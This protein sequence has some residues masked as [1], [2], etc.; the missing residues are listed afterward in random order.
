M[1]GLCFSNKP[2]QIIKQLWLKNIRAADVLRQHDNVNSEHLEP[3][4][5]GLPHVVDLS[6]ARRR[7][8]AQRRQAL[9]RPVESDEI[10]AL[11]LQNMAAHNAET[12]AAENDEATAVRRHNDAL[13]V[14][15]T[16][17]AENDEARAVR[18]QNMAA[19]NA[20]TRAA[21]NDEARAVRLQN[22]AANNAATRAAENDEARA[23]RLQNMAANNAATR[24]AENDEAAAVRRRNVA[25]RVAARRADNLPFHNFARRDIMPE[26]N[27]IGSMT[28]VCE[29]CHALK[30]E[31]ENSF[32]C[33]HG[34]KVSLPN[35]EPY[36][37]ELSD[38]MLEDT[39]QG[40]N[41]RA[42]I[43][44]F[45]SAF[46]F[47]SFGANIAPPPGRGP[48]CFRL[49]GQVV[50]RSGTLH[51]EHGFPPSYSQLY[52][53]DGQ[54]ALDERMN[55]NENRNCHPD[56]MRTIQ[57]VMHRDNPYALAFKHMSEVEQ[58]EHLIA[59]AENRLP[60]EV[61]MYMKVAG[62][63]RRYNLPHHDEVAAV[64]VGE[65]GAPPTSRGHYGLSAK[66]LFGN[67]FND[68]PQPRPHGISYL[69]SKR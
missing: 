34:G 37:Q 57:N 39:A 44:Q 46:S 48:P 10:R 59:A 11:R 16:R 69:L 51:P 28:S 38:L 66:S 65:D 49:C 64:F 20:A 45:N 42:N 2:H 53:Y 22:M 8:N 4:E 5:R 25:R 30:F 26:L 17:A 67:H 41:F 60:S 13:C 58:E 32:K 61:Q 24:A 9:R 18:L 23:V 62:D 63:R 3:Q 68:I 43:R 40:K 47:A 55:R 35:L 6:T 52:I 15:A 54:R 19:N 50:H 14:A 12:R 33:C 31:D 1:V 21:E 29:H 7:L 27:D 56:V 36:P